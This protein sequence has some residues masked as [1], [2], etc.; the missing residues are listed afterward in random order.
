MYRFIKLFL[1]NYAIKYG[2]KILEK[3]PHKIP[4]RTPAAVCAAVAAAVYIAVFCILFFAK[5]IYVNSSFY[6]KSANL[7]TVSYKAA[8]LGADFEGIVL[9]K[10]MDY[11]TIT[12]DGKTTVTVYPDKTFTVSGEEIN[13]EIFNSIDWVT[14]ANQS[15]EGIRGFGSKH[16]ALAF[17]LWLVLL[18]CKIYGV[19]LYELL[20]PNKAAG[21]GYY[22]LLDVAFY[23]CSA[24]VLIYLV[25]PL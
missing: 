23:L 2:R 8:S 4:K 21:E 6:R 9:N 24:A 14:I 1:L 25:I 10:L 11:S 20:N 22:R 18:L 5:G 16:W 7:T 15:N 19:Q 3:F 17:I 12:V 13:P